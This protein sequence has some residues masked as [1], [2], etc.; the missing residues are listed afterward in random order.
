MDLQLYSMYKIKEYNTPC[1]SQSPSIVYRG[2]VRQ[3]GKLIEYDQIH[4][5]IY[6]FSCSYTSLFKRNKICRKYNVFNN[7][8]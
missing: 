5:V 6:I 2:I 4:F 7:F 1:L 8:R 3:Y